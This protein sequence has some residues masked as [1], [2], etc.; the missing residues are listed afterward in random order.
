[1]L[2]LNKIIGHQSLNSSKI[3]KSEKWHWP[4]WF[5]KRKA[6]RSSSQ[7]VPNVDNTVPREYKDDLPSHSQAGV[8]FF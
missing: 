1:M 4:G 7:L 3:E 2:G 8:F 6:T 5:R